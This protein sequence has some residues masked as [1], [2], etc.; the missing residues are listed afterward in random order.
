M[1]YSGNWLHLPQ[2]G[3]VIDQD[4][5]EMDCIHNAWAIEQIYGTNK[6]TEFKKANGRFRIW[7]MSK[8]PEDEADVWLNPWLDYEA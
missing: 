6:D 8:K 5:Y 7:V 3:A 4:E 2:P 1:D